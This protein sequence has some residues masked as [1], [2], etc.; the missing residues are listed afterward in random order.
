MISLVL[1]QPWA[2]VLPCIHITKIYIACT[3]KMSSGHWDVFDRV[4]GLRSVRNQRCYRQL[5]CLV[6]NDDVP[7]RWF[8]NALL[9]LM[10]MTVVKHKK[11]E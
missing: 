11:I 5:A 10:I 1:T 6:L 8:C 2:E 7:S 9:V 4:K 3:E